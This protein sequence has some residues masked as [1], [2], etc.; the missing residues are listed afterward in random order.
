[1][2]SLSGLTS[3]EAEVFIYLYLQIKFVEVGNPH[4][5]SY[6][7]TAPAV[8][9]LIPWEGRVR[10]SFPWGHYSSIINLWGP[11]LRHS[12]GFTWWYHCS[13]FLDTTGTYSL[14]LWRNYC[15]VL[16]MH[17]EPYESVNLQLPCSTAHF[18]F[19]FIFLVPIA[20]MHCAEVCDL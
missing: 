19:R 18:V 6:D 12:V 2:S 14:D 17:I 7:S 9:L 10:N 1:M 13:D 16:Y 4:T 3:Q 5:I 15:V 11:D 20:Y 8:E